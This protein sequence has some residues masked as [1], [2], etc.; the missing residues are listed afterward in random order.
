MLFR[1]FY[2]QNRLEIF[3]LFEYFDCVVQFN[4][5]FDSDW[6]YTFFFLVANSTVVWEE[7]MKMY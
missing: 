6:I 4:P 1:S 7:E 2:V 5:F 3:L